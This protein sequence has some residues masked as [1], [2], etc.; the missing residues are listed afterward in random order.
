MTKR[1]VLPSFGIEQKIIY[2]VLILPA[3][4]GAGI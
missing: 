2:V 3:G 4:G 1:Y